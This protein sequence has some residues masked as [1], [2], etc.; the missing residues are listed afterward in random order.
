MQATLA[1]AL[2]AL[3]WTSPILAAEFQF[4]DGDRVVLVGSTLIEREQRYGYWELALTTRHPEKNITFRNLGWSGD[5]VWGESRVGFDLDNPKI[6]FTRLVEHVLALKPTVIIVGY[7][8]NESFA[9]EDG[10]PQFREGMNKLL[11]AFAPAKA[12]IMLLAPPLMEGVRKQNFNLRIYG[13]AI[14]DISKKRKC[15]FIDLDVDLGEEYSKPERPKRWGPKL[16]DDGMHLSEFGYWFTAHEICGIKE[17][18]RGTGWQPRILRNHRAWGI[19]IDTKAKKANGEEVKVDGLELE[20]LR[21]RA[22]DNQQPLPLPGEWRPKWSSMNGWWL[23]PPPRTL[24]VEG[25]PPGK[26]VLRIDGKEITSGSA[27]DWEFFKTIERGP[28]FDQAE[29]LRKL[30]VE[31]NRLY[32][33][34]W[35]PQNDTYLFGFRKHEQGKNAIEIP[36]F[37]PLVEKLEKEIAKLRVP[38]PHKY[39]LVPVK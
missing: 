24:T 11:D 13:T 17:L 6:G 37:D 5:T 29:K 4:K 7:G 1:L 3:A 39:E 18:Q 31:K 26:Y 33:H 27:M 16:T 22:I 35:R 10:L 21:F 38:Q 28:E 34:R 9:G 19:R 8:T 14:Q 30:I 2:A 36:K 32:F 15:G 23:W 20:P 25:L 12:R